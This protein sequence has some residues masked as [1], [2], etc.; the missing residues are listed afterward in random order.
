[1]RGAP[2]L[3]HDLVDHAARHVRLITQQ[4][5]HG[6]RARIERGDPRA[7]GRGAAVAELRVFD[8]RRGA[9]ID[10]LPDLGGRATDDDDDLIEG[11]RRRSVADDGAQQRGGAEREELL[12]L[13]ETGRG[14]GR[15]DEAGH[16]RPPHRR[17]NVSLQTRQ[18]KYTVRSPTWERYLALAT[19]TTIPQIGSVASIESAVAGSGLPLRRC[20]MISARMLTAISAGSVAPM[21]IP[22][23]AFSCPRRSLATPRSFRRSRIRAARRRLATRLT[24][25]A[26]VDRTCVSTSSSVSACVGEVPHDRIGN[27]LRRVVNEWIPRPDQL[28]LLEIRL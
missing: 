27:H 5:H 8:D 6:L 23:G 15:E 25:P 14:A 18:Q 4:H 12:G 10:A 1:R 11:G 13:A 26:S 24:Y 19:S 16:E 22:A 7:I 28:R 20:W 9:E 3:G 2:P 17:S 21:S